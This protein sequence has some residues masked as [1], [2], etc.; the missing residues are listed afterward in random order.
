[1]SSATDP[2]APGPSGGG[3]PRP[4]AAPA[5]HSSTLQDWL[6]QGGPPVTAAYRSGSADR[7]AGVVTALVGALLIAVLAFAIGGFLRALL[8]IAALVLAG[9]ATF[10]LAGQSPVLNVLS[11]PATARV[12]LLWRLLSGRAATVTDSAR[13]DLLRL[14]RPGAGPDP[15]HPTADA[16]GGLVLAPNEQRQGPVSSA[17]L[18]ATRLGDGAPEPLWYL[19][20]A[21]LTITDQRIGWAVGEQ[22][23]SGTMLGAHAGQALL[24]ASGWLTPLLRWAKLKATGQ[25]SWEWVHTV[26]FDPAWPAVHLV[27]SDG[28][29][30]VDVTLAG[31]GTVAASSVL[32]QDLADLISAQRGLVPVRTIDRAGWTV[33]TVP[34]AV[35]L[36]DPAFGRSSSPAGR[37]APGASGQPWAGRGARVLRAN[38][39]IAVIVGLVVLGL[40]VSAARALLAGPAS[41][42]D[43]C[44]QYGKFSQQVSASAR[45]SD[46]FDNKLF[47]AA[48]DLGDKAKRYDNA[49]VKQAGKTL[50]DIGDGT[51]TSIGQ[52]SSAA[53][54][55]AGICLGGGD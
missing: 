32:G 43:L 48:G 1:M 49:T 39:R 52:L 31:V 40:L 34:G 12:Y 26:A 44:A 24:G 55:I 54:P 13:H 47:R 20:A 42:A 8:I 51:S 17:A 19:P 37:P 29:G 50:S 6:A 14:R 15:V 4:A 23:R 35:R 16:A 7:A 38:P 30:Q 21:L 10:L 9:Y 41:T 22:Q 5:G 36:P 33:W 25:L 53:A 3:G 28:T 46:F 18:S 45:S 27:A 2:A 11:E